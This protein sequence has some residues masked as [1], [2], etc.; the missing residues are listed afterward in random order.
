MAMNTTGLLPSC[1]FYIIDSNHNYHFL[2]DTG[3][4]VSVVPP[5]PAESKHQNGFNLLAVNG[6]GIAT[7]GKHSL[8]MNLG[9]HRNFRWV[10]IVAD[11]HTPI[12]GADFLCH[13]DQLVD[14]KQSRLVDA[15]TQL[16][17]QGILSQ[18]TS[19]SPSFLPYTSIL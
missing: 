13:Y 8:T 15:I 2:V 4:E 7:Y 6:S 1:L 12:L 19:P 17:V 16:R 10:F 18:T 3:A 5:S 14:M 9:L 11:V